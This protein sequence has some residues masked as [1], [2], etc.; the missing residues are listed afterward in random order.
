MMPPSPNPAPG[1][2]PASL[3]QFLGGGGNTSGLPGAGMDAD[4]GQFNSLAQM[5]VQVEQLLMQMQ[6]LSPQAAQDYQ[7][8]IAL[9][10]P[11]LVKAAQPQPMQTM[12]GAMT[13]GGGT[14]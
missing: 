13:P 9:L 12:S 11:A 3:G 5:T 2:P 7:Q 6:Q 8:M 10:R 4:G 14:A 1:G